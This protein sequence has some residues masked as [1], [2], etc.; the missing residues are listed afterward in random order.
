LKLKQTTFLIPFFILGVVFKKYYH[1][2]SV[3]IIQNF[4]HILGSFSLAYFILIGSNY[5]SDLFLVKFLYKNLIAVLGIIFVYTLFSS[6][7][8]TLIYW[9]SWEGHDRHLLYTLLFFSFILYFFP[10]FFNFEI[11]LSVILLSVLI[12]VGSYII[13]N[14]INRNKVASFLLFG[15]F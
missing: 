9:I 5:G 12:L 7:H 4:Y 13:V 1:I 6:C 15:K 8:L 2:I 14:I 11:F 3:I 10:F